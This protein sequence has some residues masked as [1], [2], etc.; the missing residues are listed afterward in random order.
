MTTT[1]SDVYLVHGHQGMGDNIYQRPFVRAVAER[2][3]TQV[4]TPWP[5]LFEDLGVTFVRPEAR[6]RTQSKNIV[7][8]P[9]SRWVPTHRDA[10]GIRPKYSQLDLQQGISI[11]KAMERRCNLGTTPYVFDLPES[12]MG[13]PL[14]GLDGPYAVVR[15]VTERVEWRALS[16]GPLPEYV[17]SAATMLRDRG[18]MVVTVADL[19]P[20]REWLVGDTAPPADFDLLA[21]QLMF[22]DLMRL[23]ANA[24]VVVGGVG[25]IVPAA[26][27]AGVSLI[28]ILGG[29]GAFNQ[30]RLLTDPRMDL[31]R[32]EWI[33]PDVF[34]P[35][36]MRDHAC[37]KTI[38]AFP[39]KFEA[40]LDRVVACA[41]S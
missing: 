28:T 21:G 7:R 3:P 18:L 2:G 25:W 9:R 38:T 33:E 20:E 22:S 23:I 35:C 19:A 41:S 32:V 6:L 15:P 34:C 14:K 26:I 8:Q 29:Q 1:T 37:R 11:T 36:N 16:R 31:R 39:A 24:A 4:V 27:A 40:A 30:P 13:P 5:E 12:L 17:T 10:V